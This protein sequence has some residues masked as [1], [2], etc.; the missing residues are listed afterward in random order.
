MRLLSV[1]SVIDAPAILYRLLIE[2]STE[3]D[4][5]INI[6][7]RALPTPEQHMEFYLSRPYAYWDLIEY[8]EAFIGYVSM[9]QNN[10]IGVMLFQRWRGLRLGPEAVELFMTLYRP[11]PPL[12][13]RRSG[14]WLANINPANEHSRKMFEKLGFRLIQHTFEKEPS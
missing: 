7:H 5:S 8:G 3:D 4:A 10:E 11:M 2:R 14:N 1:Y 9:T 6:S 12:A 13:G